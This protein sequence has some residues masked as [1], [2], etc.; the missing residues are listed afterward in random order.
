[1][2]FIRNYKLKLAKAIK[3]YKK[4]YNCAKLMEDIV[5]K[6]LAANRIGLNYF[7]LSDFNKV[8]AL[9]SNRLNISF[10]NYLNRV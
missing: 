2:Q 7:N 6:S 9:T 4:F 8:K 3:F 10:S 5:G 1:M